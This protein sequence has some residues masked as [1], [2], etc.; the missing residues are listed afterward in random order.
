MFIQQNINVNALIKC[1][2]F[3]MGCFAIARYPLSICVALGLIG[4][5]AGGI[6]SRWWQLTDMPEPIKQ[7]GTSRLPWAVEALRQRV[8]SLG[9]Q[10]RSQRQ[11]KRSSGTMQ[12]RV[13][14]FGRTYPRNSSQS[15]RRRSSRRQSSRSLKSSEPSEP[16]EPSDE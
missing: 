8:Q 9:S 10:R 7:D 1:W 4:G 11:T 5:L 12:P 15:S 16:S 2:L 6:L 13:G 14:L 3:F